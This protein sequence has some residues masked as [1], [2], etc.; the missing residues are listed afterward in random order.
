MKKYYILLLLLFMVFFSGCLHTD[1]EDKR[2]EIKIA[3][4][5][6]V[7]YMPLMYAG[8]KGMLDGLDIK[9]ISTSSVSASLE[10]AKRD[11]VDGFC[12]TQKEYKSVAELMTPIILFDKSYGG[13]KILSNM[14]KEE[15]YAMKS[16]NVEVHMEYDS[17]NYIMFKYFLQMRDWSQLSFEIKN[18][19]QNFITSMKI[20]NPSVVIAYEPYASKLVKKGFNIIETSKNP[21]LFIIDALF[22][23]RTT[24]INSKERLEKLNKMV[25]KSLLAL[26]KDPKEF[27]NTIKMYLE[28]QSYEDFM[29]TLTEI[30]WVNG[31]KETVLQQMRDKNIEVKNIL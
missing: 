31:H 15:L 17:V 20:I 27:Y 18:N 24:L 22:M 5:N 28:G 21:N 13:D 10:F 1:D 8:K 16:G 14:T 19:T 26:K 9:L 7:G 2:K 11:V 12:S 25:Q 29:S 6:W 4:S 3:V 23:K 30:Q